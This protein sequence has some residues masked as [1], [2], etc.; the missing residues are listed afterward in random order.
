MY[1]MGRRESVQT[2]FEP[3]FE[4]AVLGAHFKFQG[5][6]F[7]Q[8]DVRFLIELFTN[9]MEPLVG[10]VSLSVQNVQV[11]RYLEG[12][13]KAGWIQRS[14]KKTGE[15]PSYLLNRQGLIHL[16][17]ALVSKPHHLPLEQVFFVHYFLKSYGNL[18][19]ELIQRDNQTFSPSL[20]A[21]LSA[22]KDPQAV[23]RTQLGFVD[24]MI[25]KIEGRVEEATRAS[26]LGKE[27]LDRG[28]DSA[29][30]ISAIQT[31]Y[32]YELNNRK[33]LQELMKDLPEALRPWEMTE[34]LS[35]RASFLWK[36][37]LAHLKQYRST[38]AELLR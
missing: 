21:E 8:R 18:F 17:S 32:P 5:S 6:G 4:A 12:L 11:A 13:S 27:I 31:K 3:Y 20:K 33:P 10:D 2:Q 28:G 36:P 23:V 37:M 7:R 34:G 22:L 35:N 14:R 9:W 30:V 25:A 26:A 38:L 1:L 15:M 24:K 19:N 29:A 16:V